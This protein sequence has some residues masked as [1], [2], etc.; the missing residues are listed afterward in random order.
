VRVFSCE[1]GAEIARWRGRGEPIN[2]L[3]WSADGEALWLGTFTGDVA[4]WEPATGASRVLPAHA[5]SVKQL[6]RRGD[7]VVSVGRDGHVHAFAAGRRQASFRAGDSILNGV[8]CASRDGRLATVSRRNGLELWSERGEALA[9]FRAHPCSAKT[10][11]F[12]RDERLV[13]AGYYDGHVAVF[14]PESRMARVERVADESVSQVAF[15]R[16]GLIVSTW[17]A[18]GTLRW[19]GPRGVT[20]SVSVVA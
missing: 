6:V 18:R 11:A 12:S 3:A 5:G 4:V 7:G 10:V 20:G 14:C 15:G 8:A 19:L 1:D 13:A 17:D 16:G 2:S 9:S